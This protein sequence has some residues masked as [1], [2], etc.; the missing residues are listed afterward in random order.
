[1]EAIE[2]NIR[3]VIVTQSEQLLRKARTLMSFRVPRVF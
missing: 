1:M 2:L 3:E